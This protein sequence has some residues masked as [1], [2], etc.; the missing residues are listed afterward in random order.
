MLRSI[1][2]LALSLITLSGGLWVNEQQAIV[3]GADEAFRPYEW[4]SD[5]GKL[6]G[7]QVELIRAIGETSG[8][9]ISFVTGPW[10]KIRQSLLDGSVQVVS[11]FE[12]LMA[13]VIGGMSQLEELRQMQVRILIDDFGTGF[14]SLSHLASIPAET[15]KIDR[16]FVHGLV[17]GSRNYEIVRAMLALTRNLH[18][19]AVAEGI[20]TRHERDLLAEMGCEYAQGYYYSEPLAETAA[21]ELLK[22]NTVQP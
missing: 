13:D 22:K 17:H 8:R 5:E 15:I 18:L 19:E 3:Y 6:E 2:L 14:S 9:R 7:F 12:P 21:E 16:S 11:M 10:S 1:R 20:E 4:F